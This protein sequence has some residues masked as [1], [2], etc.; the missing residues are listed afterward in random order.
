MLLFGTSDRIVMLHYS[1]L[2]LK[3]ER[4]IRQ[5]MHAR[6]VSEHFEMAGG[7][8]EGA[9]R[10]R[11]VLLS[12]ARSEVTR[13]VPVWNISIWEEV[14]FFQLP[15]G[16]HLVES[17]RIQRWGGV[18]HIHLIAV[19]LVRVLYELVEIPEPLLRI[20][21]LE[22]TAHCE[23]DVVGLVARSLCANTLHEGFNSLLHIVIKQNRVILHGVITAVLSIEA[24]AR[25]GVVTVVKA[26]EENLCL[27]FVVG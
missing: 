24:Y 2:L 27:F 14:I 18:E 20:L 12:G 15:R 5:V 19:H 25:R 21:I 17:L 9:H 6:C 16:V 11:I 26:A 13:P 8:K 23:H 1:H 4:G 10:S 3:L 7:L 22:V